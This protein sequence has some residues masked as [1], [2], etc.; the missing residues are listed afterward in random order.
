[1]GIIDI[2][3]HKQ[4]FVITFKREQTINKTIDSTLDQVSYHLFNIMG[5]SS[6]QTSTGSP[7]TAEKK[8][9]QAN[10]QASE[11]PKQQQKNSPAVSAAPSPAT[12]NASTGNAQAPSAASSSSSSSFNAGHRRGSS[13]SYRK[14]NGGRRGNGYNHR[15]YNQRPQNPPMYAAARGWT[16]YMNQQYYAAAAAA[17]Q[18]YYY[19]PQAPAPQGFFTPVMGAMPGV[20][21]GAVNEDNGARASHPVDLP[22]KPA[23]HAGISI[24]TKDGRPVS[25][26]QFKKAENF[27]PS[28]APVTAA[29][30]T[31]VPEQKPSPEPVKKPEVVAVKEEEANKSKENKNAFKEAILA[32]IRAK[33][34]LEAQ[35]KE[36]TVQKPTQKPETAESADKKPA[37]SSVETKSTKVE[38][39]A[40]TPAKSIPVTKAE[41][42]ELSVEKPVE[43]VSK[44]PSAPVTTA[45]EK[46]EEETEKQEKKLTEP[47]KKEVAE[48]SAEKPASKKPVAEK[49]AAEKPVAEKSVTEKPAAEKPS[50]EKPSSKVSM[51][52]L[53]AQKNDAKFQP[54][55]EVE[56]P[57][58]Q[59]IPSLPTTPSSL[60]VHIPQKPT[61]SSKSEN[62]MSTAITNAAVSR[63][64]QDISE[65]QSA[66]AKEAENN[67]SKVTMSQFFERIKAA[68]PVENVYKFSYP[69]GVI[70]PDEKFQSYH[71][72]TYDPGFLYQ[73]CE[74]CDF[75]VDDDWKTKY[76]SHVLLLD[77]SGSK[78]G[79]RN[80]S[81]YGGRGMSRN[82]PRG[83]YNGSR[84]GSR[85]GSGRR[86]SGRGEKSRQGSRRRKDSHR[87]RRGEPRDMRE[88]REIGHGS[89][90]EEWNSNPEENA[91]SREA[92]SAPAIPETLPNGEPL[93]KKAEHK[94]VP[95][96]LRKKEKEVKYAPDGKTVLLEE[97][98]IRSKTQSLLNKLTLEQFD[99][100][101]GK[102]LE[103]ANQSKWE[104]DAQALKLVIEITFAKACDE[105]HWSNMYARWCFKLCK[106]V[107]PEVKD[108]K[109]EELGETRNSGS[110]LV[111]YLL[112]SRCQTEYEKG[113]EDKL[114]TNPDGSQLEPE[115]MSDEYYKMAAAKRRGL[116]LVRFIGE[117]FSY[118]LLNRHVIMRC[119]V[120]ILSKDEPSDDAME[121]LSQL[122]KTCGPSLDQTSEGKHHLD[123]AFSKIH[124]LL[125]TSKSLTSRIKFSILDMMELRK[126]NWRDEN[127][128]KSGPKTIQEI[129]MEAERKR[130]QEEYEKEMRRRHHGGRGGMDHRGGSRMGSRA[131]S[132]LGSRSNSS[133]WGSSDRLSSK[134][135]SKV[136]VVRNSSEGSLGPFKKNK[137]FQTLASLRRGRDRSSDNF[138]T[139]SGSMRSSSTRSTTNTPP[140]PEPREASVNRF[141]ALGLDEDEDDDEEEEEEEEAERGNADEDVASSNK[142][143]TED[144]VKSNGKPEDQKDEQ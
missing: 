129:H 17:A 116:G 126:R 93:L 78:G 22:A 87:S 142:E 92:A 42:K 109:D 94:W 24:K 137:T 103:V 89:R 2:K 46:K 85:G 84:N 139:V 101:T 65:S 1:M 36:A 50:A 10:E 7:A 125:D 119:I 127:A 120:E 143:S 64:E 31:P 55:G 45:V 110:N 5:S 136:G 80:G 63:L 23:S 133:R 123:L 79:Y 99:N 111:H 91:G 41:K 8:I 95:R 132:R 68:K 105:P 54:A 71:K 62:L 118:K 38:K 106:D 19:N 58:K 27:E 76:S 104:E 43:K 33:K 53:I 18:G 20:I 57:A 4:S 40:P 61:L 11:Q 25:F 35:K 59:A 90:H 135:L 138:T 107:D 66:D 48:P 60:P 39:P 49:P 32:K 6:E 112:V 72:K 97:D 114:P 37:A 16:E 69:D 140:T 26:A 15:H 44:V 77:R 51:A 141:A 131:G 128:E 13:T 30:K 56:T 81:Q 82:G 124:T 52:Q 75:E 134:D 113:W 122:L 130:E 117:L 28:N 74:A 12:V 3:N 83:E 34:A 9:A 86:R 29:L 108:S 21:P 70:L 67:V 73:F 115:M 88:M 144:N 14:N 47:V 96:S 98:D 100:I 102:M 121:T